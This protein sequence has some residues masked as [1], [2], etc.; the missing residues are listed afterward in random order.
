MRYFC[1]IICCFSIS[2]SQKEKREFWTLLSE[3][4]TINLDDYLLTSEQENILRYKQGGLCL[5]YDCKIDPNN[6]FVAI[7]LPRENSIIS[8]SNKSSK[9]VPYKVIAG[10]YDDS[11]CLYLYKKEYESTSFSF[12]IIRVLNKEHIRQGGS[13]DSII[14]IDSTVVE[15]YTY[16]KKKKSLC[17]MEHSLR[18]NNEYNSA[19]RF[20]HISDI[21]N[22]VTEKE[23]FKTVGDIVAVQRNDNF[24]DLL[25]RK[26]RGKPL[27]SLK[28]CNSTECS[29]Q[30]CPIKSENHAGK[31]DTCNIYADETM[32]TIINKR[33]CFLPPDN[34][35]SGCRSWLSCAAK[36]YEILYHTGPFAG[37]CD[38]SNWRGIRLKDLSKEELEQLKN[39]YYWWEE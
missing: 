7:I 25:I 34:P 8:K 22:K 28:H 39:R 20:C 24:L 36:E 14:S 10:K 6:A 15:K 4:D 16:I 26:K 21:L 13:A 23:L 1:I 32:T 18:F 38:L 37:D 3:T 35:I 27:T 11:T 33:P 19:L 12:D 9:K 29:L 17:E 5:F 2:F 30:N 31:A